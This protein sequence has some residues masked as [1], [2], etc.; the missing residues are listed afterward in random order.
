MLLSAHPP[1]TSPPRVACR[2]GCPVRGRRPFPGAPSLGRPPAAPQ[3]LGRRI[4][5]AAGFAGFA[6]LATTS[7]GFAATLGRLDGSVTAE[8]ALEHAGAIVTATELPSRRIWR[9]G[10]PTAP[11]GSP[12]PPGSGRRRSRRVLHRGLLR[13]RRRSDLRHWRVP[14]SASGR[15]PRSPTPDRRT[16]CSRR[17]RR[18]TST[19]ARTSTTRSPACR[20]TRRRARTCSTRRARPPRRRSARSSPRSTGRSTCWRG[21]A[22]RRSPS[23]PRLGVSRISVGGSFAFVAID[24]LVSRRA[25]AARRGDLRVR[26]ALR[27]QVRRPHAR[28]FASPG[29]LPFGAASVRQ[30]CGGDTPIPGAVVT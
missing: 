18:T 17:G 3:P 29:E 7:S 2:D 26:G 5:P 10:L 30:D 22:R 1:D 14:P 15:P 11:K 23:S 27:K 9:T 25:G 6:A 19:V 21:P 13:Q 4:R 24:A 28:R 16:S 20:P 8:E 12:R